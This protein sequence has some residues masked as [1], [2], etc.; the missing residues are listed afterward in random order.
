MIFFSNLLSVHVRL[1]F[2]SVGLP[3][4][5]MLMVAGVSG[6]P[7]L[8]A[9]F[10]VEVESTSKDACAIIRLLRAAEEAAWVWLSSRETATHTCAQVV[11]TT[12]IVFFL[13]Y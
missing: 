10:H 12:S 5:A 11:M 8:N 3:L 4:A 9:L 2:C 1:G 13:K 7:G 6:G